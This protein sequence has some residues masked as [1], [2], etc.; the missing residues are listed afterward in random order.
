[1][2]AELTRYKERFGN[3]AVPAKWS[4]NPQLGAWVSKQR[5]RA[6]TLSPAR[7]ARLDALGF[8]WDLSANNRP[9]AE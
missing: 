3:C 9:A 2:L 4:E 6:E 1:M 8:A 7:K 5:L